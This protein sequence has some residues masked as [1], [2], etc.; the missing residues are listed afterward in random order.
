MP[1]VLGSD[2]FIEWI[3]GKYYP[4]KLE[5]EIPESK[6]LA[7]GIAKIKEAVCRFYE[8]ETGDLLI[9]KRGQENEARDVPMYLMRVLNGEWLTKIAEEFK[10][11]GYSS[12]V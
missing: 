11:T 6:R 12:V 8:L 3:K 7:P 4:I 2:K 1:S 9:V 10:L 5:K